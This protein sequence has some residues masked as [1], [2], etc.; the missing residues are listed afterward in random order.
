M[1]TSREGRKQQLNTEAE[2]TLQRLWAR[3]LN[4]EAGSIGLDDSFFRLGGD[5]IAAMKLVAEAR[6]E[7][8]Q[9]A[10]ADVFRQP[11]LER[12]VRSLAVHWLFM[13]ML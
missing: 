12:L 7:G 6:K 10:V 11:R 4:I 1:R 5:S 8:L 2:R 9:L 13:S 3:V